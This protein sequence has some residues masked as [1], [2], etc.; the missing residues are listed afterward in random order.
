M[1]GNLDGSS[2]TPKTG[3]TITKV[4]TGKQET[5][6]AGMDAST[7]SGS[8]QKHER[9]ALAATIGSNRPNDDAIILVGMVPPAL[10]PKVSY[11]RGM[12]CR[13][14]EALKEKALL[15]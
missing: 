1:A 15:S 7:Y 8:S 6:D 4:G 13:S 11:R 14:T 5:R 2:R 10:H 9:P 3:R 12:Q